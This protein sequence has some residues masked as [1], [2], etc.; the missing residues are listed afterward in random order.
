MHPDFS[1][2]CMNAVV[3]QS[4][5]LAIEKPE[6]L[7]NLGFSFFLRT[8]TGED[9]VALFSSAT[10]RRSASTLSILSCARITCILL[11]GV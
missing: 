5:G 6:F 8:K 2:G 10:L 11:R 9:C 7:G 3:S 4:T 1:S